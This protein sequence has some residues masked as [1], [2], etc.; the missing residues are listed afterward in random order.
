M[1]IPYDDMVNRSMFTWILK[2]SEEQIL[3]SDIAI[4]VILRSILN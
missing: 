4:S 2:N 3:E 1:V